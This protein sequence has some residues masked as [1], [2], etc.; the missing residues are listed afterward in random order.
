MKNKFK[1]IIPLVALLLTGCE[2]TF[3][4]SS[5]NASDVSITTSEHNSDDISNSADITSADSGE[6]NEDVTSIDESEYNPANL[7]IPTKAGFSSARPTDPVYPHKEKDAV[8]R[9]RFNGYT[10]PSNARTQPTKQYD[11]FWHPQT[12]LNVEIFGDPEIFALMNEHGY[13]NPSRD[14]N[15]NDLYW[16]VTVRLTV[17]GRKYVYYEVGMRRKGNTSR[18]HHFWDYT[19]KQ[20]VTSFSFKLKFD[21]RWHKD[22]YAPFGMQKDWAKGDAAYDARNNRTI[23]HDDDFKNGMSKIDFKYNKT[24]DQSMTNQPFIFSFMQKHNV[25]SANSTLT[26]LAMNDQSFGIITINEATDKDLIRRYF[27]K[28]ADDGDLYKVGWGPVSHYGENRKGSLR[29]E[30]VY[31]KNGNSGALKDDAIIGVQNKFTGYNPAYDAKELHSSTVN[32]ANLVNLMRVLKDNEN[33]TVAEI[34]S[35]LEAVVDIDRFLTY[36]AAAYLTGNPDDLRNNGNNYYIYFDPRDN[37]RAHFIPYDYD[38]AMGL[39]WD[40][41]NI[42]DGAMGHVPLTHSKMQGNGRV[43]QEVRLYWYTIINK[44]DYSSAPSNI[45]RNENYF[46]TYQ[47]N[48]FTLYDDSYYSSDT[49]LAL[50][51]LYKDNYNDLTAAAVDKTWS[52]FTSTATSLTFIQNIGA[53]VNNA[54]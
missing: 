47:N 2:L 24:N 33:K 3:I 7:Y 44:N 22:I 50:F 48:V 31:F 42:K 43:W 51:N 36:A 14:G 28:G 4:T 53:Q 26:H 29:L 5:E 35:A 46:N 38:W 11:E 39:G 49:F 17:N 41:E 25:I 9:P 34:T 32:H 13:Y 10:Y 16:P 15:N 6:S 8:V 23:M 30:D 40:D 21:E 1:L 12:K 18:D 20:F 45:T 19:Q 27:A 37:N 52:G 54:R